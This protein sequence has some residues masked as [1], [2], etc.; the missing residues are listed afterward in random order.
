MLLVTGGF[1]TDYLDS[2]EIFQTNAQT[3]SLIASAKLPSA[4]KGFSAATLNNIVYIFGKSNSN[5]QFVMKITKKKL[6]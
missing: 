2:T 3:W 5:L 4:R 6:V 1:Y